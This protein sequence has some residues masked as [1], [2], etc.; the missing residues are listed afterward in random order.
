VHENY[1]QLLKELLQYL[2]KSLSPSQRKR[3]YRNFS[4]D[5]SIKKF[6]ENGTD[7]FREDALPLLF[8]ERGALWNSFFSF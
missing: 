3:F 7:A 8:L 2:R 6:E 4:I 1:C 5:E